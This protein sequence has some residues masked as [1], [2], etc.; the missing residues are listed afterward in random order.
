MT[1]SAQVDN[2]YPMTIDIP[3]LAWKV[4][5]PGCNPSQRIR[6]ANANT[7]AL[8]IQAGKNI[9]VN[10]SS[11]ISSLPQNLLDPCGDGAPSPLEVLFQA[12]LDPNQNTT[13]FISGGHQTS[14]FPKWLPEILSSLTIPFPLPHLDSNTSDLISSIHC[15]EMSITS[16]HRGHPRVPQLHNLK[17]P[18]SSKPSFVLRKKQPT[19]Q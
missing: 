19:S 4:L 1:A 6:L 16:P 9:T 18:A 5:V 7:G 14:T 2:P 17:F 11:L 12:L 10:V 8:S 13:V 15:S 3:V